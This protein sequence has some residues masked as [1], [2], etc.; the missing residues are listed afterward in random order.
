MFSIENECLKNDKLTSINHF[1]C[2]DRKTK[3]KHHQVISVPSYDSISTEFIFKITFSYP[4]AKISHIHT[5]HFS[6]KSALQIIKK[7][8]VNIEKR[9]IQ[10]QFNCTT[11]KKK[12]VNNFFSA[13]AEAENKWNWP[14]II[15]SNWK[16]YKERI[17]HR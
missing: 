11:K 8:K 2:F 5:R 1:Q 9:S 13:I 3:K 4:W 15:Q 7:Q 12:E 16:H 17:I 10:F 14:K 6:K